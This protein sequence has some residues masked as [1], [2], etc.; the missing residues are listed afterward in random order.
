MKRFRLRLF[1][2]IVSILAVGCDA[3]PPRG[4][5]QGSSQKEMNETSEPASDQ[6][7]ELVDVPS[8]A[9]EEPVSPPQ[10]QEQQGITIVDD[11]KELTPEEEKLFYAP[12]GPA[13]DGLL[14]LVTH[15]N[16][17]YRINALNRLTEKHGEDPKV[18]DL[19]VKIMSDKT[20]PV[21]FTTFGIV[22][23]QAEYGRFEV[24]EEM[25]TPIIAGV[26]EKQ[27]DD[28]KAFRIRTYAIDLAGY[29]PDNPAIVKLAPSLATRALEF[30]D[31]GFASIRTLGKLGQETTLFD[32][33]TKFKDDSI[34]RAAVASAMA[35]LEK[36]NEKVVEILLKE[37]SSD[38]HSGMDKDDLMKALGEARPTSDAVVELLKKFAKDDSGSVCDGAVE[39]LGAVDPSFAEAVIPTLEAIANDP[40]PSS[41]EKYTAKKALDLIRGR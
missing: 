19:L 7:R 36:P 10:K 40:D 21:R 34:S 8:E 13:P 38:E 9:V 25:L 4:Q 2:P 23:I 20:H 16:R 26:N 5:S 14:G 35:S 11:H 29:F 28:S 6:P 1:L 30:D 24:P 17:K 37:C 33:Y 18:I 15:S 32:L 31:E 41:L 3:D 39:G 12:A 22:D 27:D